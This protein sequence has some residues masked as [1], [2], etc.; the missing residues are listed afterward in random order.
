MPP[1]TSAITSPHNDTRS[2]ARQ[3]RRGGAGGRGRV[4]AT[5][6]SSVQPVDGAENDG[7]GSLN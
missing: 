4:A 1:S 7:G 3:R 6:I 2:T 5:S